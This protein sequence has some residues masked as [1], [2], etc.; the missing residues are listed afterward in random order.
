M[1]VTNLV[2]TLSI[3]LLTVI[4][5]G[6]YCGFQHR[7]KVNELQKRS[8]VRISTIQCD[9]ANDLSACPRIGAGSRA[10]SSA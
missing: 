10:I 5:Y 2:L 1:A 8:I 4:G 9:V 7:R 3:P 6:L